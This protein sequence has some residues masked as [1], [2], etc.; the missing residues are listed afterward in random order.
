MAE[1]EDGQERTEDPSGRKL[2][3]ARRKGQIPRSRELGGA[4]VLILGSLG[5]L[6][7]GNMLIN[8]GVEVFRINFT[9]SLDD[10]QDPD[11]AVRHLLE[12]GKIVLM[13]LI[14]FFLVLAVAAV[15]IPPLV[16]G[17]NFSFESVQPKLS[18]LNPLTGFKRM[19]SMQSL[20]ELVKSIAKFLLV[21]AVAVQLLDSN[22]SRLMNLGFQEPEMAMAEGVSIVMWAFFYLCCTLLLIAAVDVPF[23]LYQYKKQLMMTKQEVRDEYKETEGKPEVKSK[24]RSKQKEIAYSRMMSAVPQ[25]DVVITN[26]THF[27]VALKYDPAKML[28]PILVA[29]GA[30][31]IAEQIK[32]VALA[33]DVM[34]MQSPPLA[35]SIYYHTEL[36]REIPHGLYTA[37]AQ[38]LAYVFQLKRFQQ[39]KGP[40]PGLTPVVSVPE[41][42]RRD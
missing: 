26:P 11:M 8:A 12:S 3:E 40:N 23:Q 4:A 28:A 24:L 13:A 27:A 34:I 39:G 42:M 7:F 21:A 22:S 5:L 14:P 15:S 38:V 41:D 9:V 35:R 20:V 18:K 6:M 37:V 2:E 1:N 10:L 36:E 16:G 32:K 17:I 33:N 30:D 29:K 31:F 19:F 25:A